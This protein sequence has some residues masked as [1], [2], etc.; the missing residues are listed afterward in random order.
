MGTSNILYIDLVQKNHLVTYNIKYINEFVVH[1]PQQPIFKMTKSGL[2]Y[3]D[4]RHLLKNKD[5]HIMVNVSR[6]PIP[7]VKDNKKVYTAHGIKISDNK[8]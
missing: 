8:R 2:F 4:M 7:Q 3:H 6:S 5:V 1:I